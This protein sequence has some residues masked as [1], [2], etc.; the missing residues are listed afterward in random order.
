MKK[1][2]YGSL[3]ALALSLSACIPGTAVDLIEVEVFVHDKDLAEWP[4]LTPEQRYESYKA[5]RDSFHILRHVLLDKPL[6]S[7]L[8]D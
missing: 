7:D 3:A 6:P 2:L 1:V 4:T 5:S 8:A